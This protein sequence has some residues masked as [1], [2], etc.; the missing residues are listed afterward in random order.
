LVAAP[1]HSQER[2]RLTLAW[3]NCRTSGGGASFASFACNT[4]E[5]PGPLLVAAFVPGPAA[6][7][8]GMEAAD[9]TLLI[10]ARY[11][12]IP[13]WW[14]LA[15][16]ITGT[17]GCRSLGATLPLDLANSAG[18]TCARTYWPDVGQPVGGASYVWPFN[19]QCYLARLRVVVA[20]DHAAAPLAPQP[21]PGQETHLFSVRLGRSGTTGGGA[22]A[23]CQTPACLL[24]DEARIFQSNGDDFFIRS[25]FN[26]GLTTG[27]WEVAWQEPQWCIHDPD[28]IP[29]CLPVRAV[30]RTWGAIKAIYR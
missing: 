30:N 13:P 7:L 27:D 22:C 14:Q 6:N 28:E 18:A 1:A 5:G 26:T 8:T 4:N 24:F 11:Y 21:T 16:P 29:S 15:D 17:P 12:Q 9:L 20:V 25:P 2:G 23:G 19:S 10:D 3:E